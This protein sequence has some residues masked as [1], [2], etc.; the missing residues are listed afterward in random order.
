MTKATPPDGRRH[1]GGICRRM[2]SAS[3]DA[4]RRR[5]DGDMVAD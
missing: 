4:M 5:C 3:P 2:A 1:G